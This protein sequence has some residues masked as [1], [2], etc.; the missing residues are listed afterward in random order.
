[1]VLPVV[2][3]T[4]PGSCPALH[5]GAAMADIPRPAMRLLLLPLFLSVLAS[6]QVAPPA[7]RMAEANVALPGAWSATREGRAGVDADWVAR[8]GSPR[9][10]ALIAEAQAHNPDLKIAAARVDQAR[11][12]VK[13]VMGATRPTLE[14]ESAGNTNQRNFVGFPLPGNNGG[15]LTT[16]TENYNLSFVTNWELDIWGRY[17]AATGAA[18]AAAQS[19]EQEQR[20]ARAAIAAQTARTYF[21]LL[22]AT[23]QTEL[24]QQAITAFEDTTKSLEERFRTGQA[25]DQGGLGAQLR[26]ARSD[27]AAARAAL[28]QRREVQGQAARALEILLGRYPQGD[29][30][31][32]ETL[33]ALTTTPP[34]G[35]PS[36]LL[37]RR[38]DILAAERR[39]A[40]QG[41]RQKE[42]VRAAWPSL[43]LTGSAG[44]STAALGDVLNSN[45]GIWSLGAKI[46]EPILT[47]GRVQA[48]ITKRRAEQSEA[49]AALQKTVLAAFGEVENAL[50]SESLLRS[51]EAALTE[52]SRLASEAD[53]EARAN[54]RQ[55]LGDILTVMAAQQRAL[56]SKSALATLRRLRLDNRIALHLALGGDFRVRP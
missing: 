20:A 46:F 23:E 5:T 56:Q 1:M 18:I 7:S 10:T 38:P 50:A 53:S 19:A 12:V 24:A 3:P 36:E 16:R 35:L 47:G 15:V 17:R 39:F 31:R 2:N 4:P 45:F 33:P 14:L 37:Q 11:T 8:M 22:E 51:R 30:H 6:C 43:K 48:E 52:A 49:L 44:T 9:L 41:M 32:G 21:L 55:G 40:A 27:A 42:A 54:F 28:E 25:P 26:L 13:S 34:A 29:R